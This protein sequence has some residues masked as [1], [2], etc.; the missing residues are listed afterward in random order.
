MRFTP[1]TRRG[2]GSCMATVGGRGGLGEGA[3]G[4]VQGFGVDLNFVF[5]WP[6]PLVFRSDRDGERNNFLEGGAFGAKR[7]RDMCCITKQS[8]T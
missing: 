5:V 8:S 3:C 4:L 7:L 2:G 1:R 6:V